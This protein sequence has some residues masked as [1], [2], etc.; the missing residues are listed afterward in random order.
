MPT[1]ATTGA[2]SATTPHPSDTAHAHAT[3][4][5][6]LARWCSELTEHRIIQGDVLAGLRTLPDG[7]I[8]TVVT[9]PPYYWMRNYGV[10]G[11][12][13]LEDTPELFVQKI[14][15]VFREVRRVLRDDGTLWLNFGDSYSGSMSTKGAVI[16]QNTLSAGTGQDTGYRE[17]PLG[18]IP[19][20]KA[21]DMIGVPWRV[22]FALQADGWYLRS[23]II[24]NKPNPMPESVTDRPTKSHEYIFL[25]TK[26]ARYY[27]DAEAIR[28]E[29]TTNEN[30][31]MGCDRARS[32]EGKLNLDPNAP[33]QFKVSKLMDT[34]PQ[35]C[36]DYVSAK[37]KQFK[38]QD[39][40]GNPTYTGFNERWKEGTRRTTAGSNGQ[41]VHPDGITH[42]LG[43]GITRNARTVWTIATQARPEAH[44]ATFPDEIPRRCISAG[45]SERGC[46]PKCGKPWERIVEP[47][48]GMLG[49]SWH[50]HTNDEVTGQKAPNGG[51]SK[52][53]RRVD[54]GWMPGC[55]CDAGEP[56]PCT[57]LDPFLGSGTTMRIAR[58]LCRSSIGIEINPV[59]IKIARKLLQSDSQLDTGVVSYRYEVLA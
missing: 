25:L 41:Q 42:D 39:Q 37:F 27:Y 35:D 3:T 52:T 32:Y 43:N 49:K 10:D 4:S 34:D 56:I 54:K 13:G 38:K 47:T 14:V 8:Q 22:A 1:P 15:E 29:A 48:G 45:T 16:N 21:K 50:P 11:Q 30:R 6:I 46:C 55:K 26:N 31:P 51:L 18:I 24:W 7:I 9:S 20:L 40:T 57:V 58:D 19:G 59:Y 17:K 44:F 23:D 28:E 5:A 2:P 53:Y 12:L 36:A 33:K